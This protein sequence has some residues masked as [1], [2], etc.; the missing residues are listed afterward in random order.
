MKAYGF[1]P[2]YYIFFAIA[3][4]VLRRTLVRLTGRRTPISA[5]LCRAFAR[6]LRC[7]ARHSIGSRKRGI[8]AKKKGVI[9]L[10]NVAPFLH[11]RN[12]VCFKGVGMRIFGDANR[13]RDAVRDIASLFV[14][15]CLLYLEIE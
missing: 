8:T 9:L 2:I 11:L 5:P 4:F 15:F 3:V 13:K 7:A 14:R 6:T 10:G 12:L 1:L